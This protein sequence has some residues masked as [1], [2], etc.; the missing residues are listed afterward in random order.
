MN[1]QSA[2][3]GGMRV[4]PEVLQDGNE[5]VSPWGGFG[6][7]VPSGTRRY[8]LIPT[9]DYRRL[10]TS[11]GFGLPTSFE[12]LFFIVNYQLS[13]VSPSAWARLRAANFLRK[14]I[15]HCQL[16]IVNCQLKELRLGEAPRPPS[17]GVRGARKKDFTN[18]EPLSIIN[19]QLFHPPRGAA[20]GCRLPSK[21][22]FSL[23]IVNCQLSI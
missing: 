21:A 15:F 6:L 13:I 23:S 19:C 18:L 2:L 3:G 5:K 14:P 8:L 4:W 12:S 11:R 17:G 9:L 20:S 7:P 16:S 1:I 22:Y 10:C